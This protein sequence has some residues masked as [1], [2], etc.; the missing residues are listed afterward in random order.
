MARD[1]VVNG[2]VLCPLS[3]ILAAVLVAA[4]NLSLAQPNAR[5]GTVDHID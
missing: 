2:E 3:T 4:E 1:D 5:A